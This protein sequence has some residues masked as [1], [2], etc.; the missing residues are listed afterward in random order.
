MKPASDIRRFIDRELL[1][2]KMTTSDPL[3]SGALDSLSLEQ[4]IAF[5]EERFGV[6][7]DEGDLTGD[8]FRS[9]GAL[10]EL[11]LRKLQRSR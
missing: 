5:V 8:G 9:T 2:G 10:G 6:V 11:V 4:L 7:F 1:D 3:E